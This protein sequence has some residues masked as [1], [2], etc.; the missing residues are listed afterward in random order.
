MVN[1]VEE[2]EDK[3]TWFEINIDYIRNSDYNGIYHILI[4]N[5]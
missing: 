1:Q 2:K 3:Y 4:Y 5:R